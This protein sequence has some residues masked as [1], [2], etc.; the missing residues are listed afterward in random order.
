MCE[1]LLDSQSEGRRSK[2][3]W[4][5]RKKTVFIWT[6]R[7]HTRHTV[8]V[9]WAKQKLSTLVMMN[10]FQCHFI[11]ISFYF[12]F[13]FVR[14]R[15]L[16]RRTH[17][18]SVFYFV[19]AITALFR[20]SEFRSIFTSMNMCSVC[21]FNGQFISLPDIFFSR[22]EFSF[23]SISSSMAVPNAV[24]HEDLNTSFRR[25]LRDIIYG[26][27]CVIC[28]VYINAFNYA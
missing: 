12:S 21:L 22:H 5:R 15:C 28:S 11:S 26:F 13:K 18:I 20:L 27:V 6:A 17:I 8:D 14:R 9:E 10:I 19:V 24:G 4:R 7:A 3:S 16:S 2:R 1:I 23:S 25:R